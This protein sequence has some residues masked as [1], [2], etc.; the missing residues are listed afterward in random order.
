MAINTVAIL[1]PGDMGHAVGRLLREHELRVVTCLTGRSERTRALSQQAGIADVP[2]M[3]DLIQQSDLVMS[4]TV[5]E[6]APQVCRQVADAIRATRRDILFAECNAI[7]PS[8]AIEM[9]PIISDAGGRFVDVSIIGSPPR[10]GSSPRFYTSGARATEFEEM[11]GFGLDVRNIGPNIGQASGIK[12]CYAAMTKGTAALHTELLMAAELMGL[13]Q[14]L[15]EEFQSG[16]GAVYQRMERGIP[17]MPAKSRRWVSE[18]E[19]IE[20]TFGQLGMTPHILEGV[21]DMY[22]LVGDTPL[23]EETPE[24]RDRERSLEETIRLLAEA[25]KQPG[26]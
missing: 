3:N 16:Q 20:A 26:V 12:M 18:M 24:A 17:G 9:E 8:K 23:G 1:S 25:L 14:P 10:N 6:V 5:S 21:A 11:A 19:E 2:D 15:Q 4:I 22:R 13:F 7:A